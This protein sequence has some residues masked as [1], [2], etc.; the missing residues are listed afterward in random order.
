MERFDEPGR[1]EQYGDGHDR[2]ETAQP[3]RMNFTSEAI[4][5]SPTDVASRLST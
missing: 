2:R 1:N 3:E 5:V 4:E